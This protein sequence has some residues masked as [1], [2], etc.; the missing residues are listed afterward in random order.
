MYK[1]R[2]LFLQSRIQM[3]FRFDNTAV[4]DITVVWLKQLR[5]LALIPENG[6]FVTFKET[7]P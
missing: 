5:L 1:F 7:L 6:T 2:E 3:V 4:V